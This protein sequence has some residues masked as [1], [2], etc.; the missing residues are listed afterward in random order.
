MGAQCALIGNQY[1]LEVGGQDFYLDLLFYHFRLRC[2]VVIDLKIGA[3][4]PEDAGKMNFY[5]SGERLTL[6]VYHHPRQ[7]DPGHHA[8][9]RR[10]ERR[11]A[12]HRRRG[13]GWI[14]LGRDDFSRSQVRVLDIRGMIWESDERYETID[15]ALAA[16]EQALAEWIGEASSSTIGRDQCAY[17][18]APTPTSRA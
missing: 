3:F 14:E 10:R 7:I 13:D 15:Q 16:A 2:F 11:R 1:H 9:G 18:H 4:Q 12:A 8:P 6:H 5:L 17:A